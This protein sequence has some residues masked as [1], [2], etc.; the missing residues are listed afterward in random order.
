M[1]SIILNQIAFRPIMLTVFMPKW[2]YNLL[3]I[4]QYDITMLTAKV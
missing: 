4:I 1:V 3:K 2:T